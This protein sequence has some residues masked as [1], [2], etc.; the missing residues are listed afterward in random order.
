MKTHFIR[1][2]VG[3]ASIVIIYTVCAPALGQTLECKRRFENNR[4]DP[5]G[6][7]H[8]GW[9]KHVIEGKEVPGSYVA[10]VACPTGWTPVSGSVRYEGGW[11]D[12][13]ILDKWRPVSTILLDEEPWPRLQKRQKSVRAQTAPPWACVVKWTGWLEPKPP[14]PLW[15]EAVCCRVQ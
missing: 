5:N 12:T 11:W 13:T 9:F 4:V 7:V 15:C 10:L 8:Q 6:N 14:D 2:L 3:M 1:S